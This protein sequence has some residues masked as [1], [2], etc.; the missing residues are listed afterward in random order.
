MK[1]KLIFMMIALQMSFILVGMVDITDGHQLTTPVIDIGFLGAITGLGNSIDSIGTTMS[2][3]NTIGFFGAKEFALTFPAINLQN[4]ILAAQN[5]VFSRQNSVDTITVFKYPLPLFGFLSIADTLIGLLWNLLKLIV[6]LFI[7][8]VIFSGT[9]YN[10][11]LLLVLPH[12]TIST[13]F[14]FSIGMILGLLQTIII[15]YEFITMFAE[16]KVVSSGVK[17]DWGAQFREKE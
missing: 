14:A 11:I 3:I 2:G 16:V 6:A 12:G 5:L 4:L 9:V 15:V 10:A 8:C 13:G 7:T 17:L 1:F